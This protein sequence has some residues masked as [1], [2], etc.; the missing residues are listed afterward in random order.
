MSVC[1]SATVGYINGS[2]EN[3]GPESEEPYYTG[4]KMMDQAKR[5]LT[6]IKVLTVVNSLESSYIIYS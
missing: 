5:Y 6:N 4:W 1:V 2:T 3:L